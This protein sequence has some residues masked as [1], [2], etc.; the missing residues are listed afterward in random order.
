MELY[1]KGK[2][3]LEERDLKRLRHRLLC[4]LTSLSKGWQLKKGAASLCTQSRR[5]QGECQNIGTLS[6]GKL[7][8]GTCLTKVGGTHI[9]GAHEYSRGTSV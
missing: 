8:K 4:L 1:K 9:L 6:G 2:A 7:E 3:V 5:E